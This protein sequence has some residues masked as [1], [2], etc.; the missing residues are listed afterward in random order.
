MGERRQEKGNLKDSA[1]LESTTSQWWSFSSLIP[2]FAGVLWL[3]L[4]VRG[5]V[6]EI[7]VGFVPGVML[8]GTGLS[9]LLW[10]VDSRT[11]QHMALASSLGILFS[12]PAIPLFGPLTAAALGAGSAASFLATGYLA[13][14]KHRCPPGVPMPETGL[15]L[16]ARAA[17]NELMMCA[18]ILT[19]WPIIVGWSATRVRREAA[20]AYG[21][22]EERGW[23]EDPASYHK[24]PPPLERPEVHYQE[25]RGRKIECLT[26]ESLYEPHEGETGR[27]RW[28]GYEK[29]RTVHAWVLRHDEERPWLV[30][31][32][33]IRMGTLGKSLTRFRPEYLHEELGLNLLMPV[34]PLHGPRDTGL[35]SGE[36]TL[37]GD[38]MDTLHTGAQAVWDLRRLV[39]WL[40]ATEGAPAM[41][42]LGHSL[43]GYAVSL[44]ASLEEDLDCAVA[45]NPAVDP[46]DLF[47]T[48]TLAVATHSLSAEGIRQD[49]FRALLRPV[50]PLS[51]EPVV[52]WRRAIFAGTVDRVI[53]PVQA[54]GLWQHWDQPRIEW[55]E[56]AHQRFL[57]APEGRKVLEDTL[58]VAGM[59]PGEVRETPAR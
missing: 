12:L 34:L 45:G 13:L 56:G 50:S 23:F 37:S 47:W 25:R 41:G 18:L 35:V 29:N 22:F 20:D 46:S 16:A 44:L 6:P 3:L 43:G 26:F 15:S 8:L 49:T 59:L 4:A 7:L 53:T 48:N 55:Y 2:L 39:S 21:L 31:V 42:A 58:R 52:P 10:A 28:L 30:C 11:Y 36:R 54:H 9:G 33:G 14:G 51:L 5:G 57:R 24:D 40:R 19:S 1:V 32:H 27:E 38:V 17:V